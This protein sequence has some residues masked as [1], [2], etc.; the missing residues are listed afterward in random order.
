MPI[1][2][3]IV[4]KEIQ[5]QSD[6]AIVQE[7][8]WDAESLIIDTTQLPKTTLTHWLNNTTPK[9]TTN[10]MQFHKACYCNYR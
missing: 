10:Y 6:K 3:F 2:I 7:V 1:Y 8:E 4:Y 9:I 5:M